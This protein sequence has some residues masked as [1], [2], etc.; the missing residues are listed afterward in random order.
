[1]AEKDEG[2]LEIEPIPEPESDENIL[3]Q[4]LQK[5][6]T[7]GGRAPVSYDSIKS[8]FMDQLMWATAATI[9]EQV[10]KTGKYLDFIRKADDKLFNLTDEEIS[11][12]SAK[13]LMYRRNVALVATENLLEFVRK[14]SA[15]NKEFFE[16]PEDVKINKF[17]EMLSSMDADELEDVIK[18]LEDHR[19]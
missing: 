6:W 17:R 4:A 5:L 9:V 12:L 2:T 3:A 13:E 8:S 18:F 16:G 14:F 10:I 19:K 7:G 1:M 11:Q 15:Q